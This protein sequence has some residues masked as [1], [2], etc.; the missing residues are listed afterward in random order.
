MGG[1]QEN[2]ELCSLFLFCFPSIKKLY[3]SVIQSGMKKG[4]KVK[5]KL[6]NNFP[7]LPVQQRGQKTKSKIIIAA[8]D[9][10]SEYGYHKVTLRM[11]S[12][13]AGVALGAPYK[14]FKDKIDILKSVVDLYSEI[15]NREINE[16]LRGQFPSESKLEEALYGEIEIAAKVIKAH[17]TLHLE[18]VRIAMTNEEMRRFYSEKE[19]KNGSLLIDR[20]FRRYKDQIKVKNRELA[21]FLFHKCVEEIIQY[22]MYYPI[23]Y[24][25]KK[26]MKELARM[27][28]RYLVTG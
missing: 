11:I 27:F 22:I 5:M 28:E 25:Q 18:I 6:N 24:N 13:K 2:N 7:R 3:I 9:L 4:K 17:Y 14:Y 10:I 19:L 12:K 16:E 8:Y 23:P 21:I 26:I 15:F 20:L 1:C